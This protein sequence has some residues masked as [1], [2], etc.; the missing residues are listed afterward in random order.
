MAYD[1]D[2][3]LLFQLSTSNILTQ[4]DQTALNFLNSEGDTTVPQIFI[5]NPGNPYGYLVFI[6]PELRNITH[7]YL[8][9]NVSQFS[10]AKTVT[11]E[12]SIDTTN[13]LDGHWTNAG[14]LT[15]AREPVIPNYREHIATLSLGGIKALRLFYPQ[16]GAVEVLE[17]G[18]VHLY[19]YKAAGET[20]HRID[21][22]YSDADDIMIDFDYGDQPR[23][24]SRTWSPTD[25][26]NQSGGL[27]LRNRSPDKVAND[28][29]LSINALT[30]TMPS[31]T[32]ISKDNSSYSTVLTWTEIQPLSM[33]GPV[34]V[35]HETD[36]DEVLGVRSERLKV[37][38]GSWV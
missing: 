20:P 31:D 34:Y 4:A 8:K 15:S 36:S 23:N 30:G 35:K 5:A 21:F 25:T 19:G 26:Y 27:Y 18:K 33:V 22:V 9:Q 7:A 29:Q 2:G 16:P 32:T 3:T 24:T 11:I 12:W 10:V 28:V 6:F 37:S 14:T 1:S 38:V 17:I 13:G